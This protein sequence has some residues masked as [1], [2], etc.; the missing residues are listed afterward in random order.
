MSMER[1]MRFFLKEKQ[2]SK[3][4]KKGKEGT[5]DMHTIEKNLKGDERKKTNKGITKYAAKKNEFMVDR[6]D[7]MLTNMAKTKK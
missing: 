6:S 1:T 7:A 4:K 2:S 5:I 3:R